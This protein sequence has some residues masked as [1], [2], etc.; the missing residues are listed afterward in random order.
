MKK[1]SHAVGRRRPA[2]VLAQIGPGGLEQTTESSGKTGF[3]ET[4]GAPGGA[5]GARPDE[6]PADLRAVILDWP[7]LSEADRRAV[8]AIV[9]R[10]GVGGVQK[11]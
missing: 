9:Q 5:V 1:R 6:M 8:L 4:G 7:H 10:A 11:L 2:N 3:P